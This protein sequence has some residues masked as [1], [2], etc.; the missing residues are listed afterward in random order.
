MLADPL[1]AIASNG[2]DQL[3]IDLVTIAPARNF[4][5]WLNLGIHGGVPAQY[6]S[7]GRV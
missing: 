2:S 5:M 4:A 6:I 1:L 7:L 3:N